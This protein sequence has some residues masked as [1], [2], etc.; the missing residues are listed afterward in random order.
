MHR[1]AVLEHERDRIGGEHDDHDQ[2]HVELRLPVLPELVGVEGGAAP[3]THARILCGCVRWDG[4]GHELRLLWGSHAA[5]G[6][7]TEGGAGGLAGEGAEARAAEIAIVAGHIG[8][9]A[10]LSLGSRE[11]GADSAAILG[12]ISRETSVAAHEN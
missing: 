1:L 6:V 12:R 11:A 4:A 9:F 2:L 8:S 7:H 3:E 10:H 5:G